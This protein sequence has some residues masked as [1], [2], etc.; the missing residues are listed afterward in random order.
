MHLLTSGDVEV[1]VLPI[2]HANFTFSSLVNV[3]LDD[4]PIFTPKWGELTINSSNTSFCS[5]CY[6]LIAV[7]TPNKFIG[8]ILFLRVHDPIPLTSNHILKA[9]LTAEFSTQTYIYH[10]LSTFELTFNLVSGQ[11]SVEIIDPRGEM[12][13]RESIKDKRTFRIESLE[14]K[15]SVQVYSEQT[16]FTVRV[17]AVS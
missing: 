4:F 3:P 5:N 17:A 10:S 13:I 8:Q 6:Y 14:Y 2:N 16:R 12:V 11:I 9:W 15:G 7:T 1:R